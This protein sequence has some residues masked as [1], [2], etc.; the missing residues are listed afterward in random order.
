MFDNIRRFL[1]FQLTV[2][3]AALAVTFFGAL[4][5]VNNHHQEDGDEG[6]GG[7]GK[8]AAKP[9]LNA[10]MML[11]INLIMDTLGAL[12]LATEKP[13]DD[14]LLR[15]PY[16]LADTALLNGKMWRH[17]LTQACFQLCVLWWLLAASDGGDGGGAGGVGWCTGPDPGL[18][19]FEL[20]YG[21]HHHHHRHQVNE[22]LKT[23]GVGGEGAA[24]GGG[25]NALLLRNTLAFN[26][27]VFCQLFNEFNS[28]SLGDDWK[29]AFRGITR[30]P[31]FLAVIAFT[32]LAQFALVTFGG[33]FTQTVPLSARQ[34]L[35]TVT[36][37]AC[38]L[39]VGVLMRF[40]PAPLD[41]EDDE[42]DESNKH[43]D[44]SSSKRRG[45]RSGAPT[46]AATSTISPAKA[47]E[48]TKDAMQDL[49][50]LH[51]SKPLKAKTT[52][53]WTFVGIGALLSA[54]IAFAILALVVNK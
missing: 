46:T 11:W 42:N 36:L 22:G 15:A 30:N 3:V 43:S 24:G 9:P 8:E 20:K 10:V 31:C 12:A 32:V 35:C 13:T 37:G 40:L 21:H 16:R 53:D 2:N 47:V 7:G 6:G 5:Q 33:S 44:G 34:W 17:I 27:F 23:K 52:W 28:R 41:D 26:A 45:R 54:W 51:E 14:L 25:D 18:S 49:T 4:M 29:A 19:P 39:P 50:G 38:S 48:L 1:Q